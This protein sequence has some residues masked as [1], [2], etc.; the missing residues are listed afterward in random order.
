V[1][2]GA[3]VVVRGSEAVEKRGCGREILGAELRE[4]CLPGLLCACAP[5]R[6]Q[7]ASAC[8]EDAVH[9]ATVAFSSSQYSGPIEER[10]DV[11]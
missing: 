3:E 10:D 11:V 5:L 9:D 6:E 4:L 2:V 8:G 1:W 7:F